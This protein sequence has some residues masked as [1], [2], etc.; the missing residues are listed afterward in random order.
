M[1]ADRRLVE[2]VERVDQMGAE[3]VR[4]G[5]A[6][7]FAARQRARL[8]VEREIPESHVVD[9]PDAGAQLAHNVIRHALLERRQLQ[10]VQPYS[11]ICGRQRRRL[12]DRLAPHSHRQRLRLEPRAGAAR[13]RL[14][15]LVLP[16]EHADVLLVAFLLEPLEEGKH[17][18]VAAARVVQ[19]EMALLRRDVLPGGVEVDVPRASRLAQQAAAPLVARL[20]PRIERAIGQRTPRIGHDQRT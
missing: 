6:L 2:H 18:Q 12:G 11:E 10:M 1:Q 3:R 13:A 19:Q 4:E 9:E 16:Q 14:G 5:N 15:E 8:P 7:R 17:P 20:G